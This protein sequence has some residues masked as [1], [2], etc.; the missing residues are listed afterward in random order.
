MTQLHKSTSYQHIHDTVPHKARHV[1][2][3]MTQLHIS[4]LLASSWHSSTQSLYRFCHFWF[5]IHRIPTESPYDY[6]VR[7]SDTAQN[8]MERV[9]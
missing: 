2:M 5:I 8:K 6:T 1:G 3:F 9:I 7:G 4:T